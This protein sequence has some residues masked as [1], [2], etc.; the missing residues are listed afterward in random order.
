MRIL[1]TAL[2]CAA[3]LA[4]A[5]P[6]ALAA[7]PV[8]ISVGAPLPADLPFEAKPFGHEQGLKIW[9]LVQSE[10][11]IGFDEESAKVTVMTLD[12]KDIASSRSG[13]PTW[14]LD[15]FPKVSEDGKYAVFCVECSSDVFGKADAVKMAGS[16]VA[17]TGSDR[18]DVELAF[19]PAKPSNADVGPL[20]VA[21]GAKGFSMPGFGGGDA[22]SYGITISG[23]LQTIAAIAVVDGDAKLESHGWSG[24]GDQRSY[25]FAKPKG[26]APKLK[27]SYWGTSAR[28]Q[29]AF[30]R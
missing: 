15:S 17:L 10:D 27:L 24:G 22:A 5:E 14:K 29:V 21:F 25:T 20:K 19:D 12:G 4:A 11:L 8:Q 9:W 18:K 16:V 1:A 2:V 3:G 23:P 6:A 26:A 13:K 28:V 30:K 7:K